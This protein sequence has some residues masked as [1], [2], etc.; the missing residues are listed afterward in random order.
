[1]PFLGI[2]LFSVIAHCWGSRLTLLIGSAL[3][4]TSWLLVYFATKSS[5]FLGGLYIFQLSKASVLTVGI[6]YIAEITEPHLRSVSIVPMNLYSILGYYLFSYTKYWSQNV[7]LLYL[8]FPVLGFIVIFIAPESP[9]WL[10]S[11]KAFLY[12]F[13]K[14]NNN[15]FILYTYINKETEVHLPFKN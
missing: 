10:A 1:M 12:C 2:A 8:S 15:F 7:I 11:K 3:F 6:T 14:N 9:H 5:A 4:T 13:N